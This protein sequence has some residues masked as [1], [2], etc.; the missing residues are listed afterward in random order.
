MF[1][2]RPMASA[3][4][5]YTVETASVADEN[6]VESPRMQLQEFFGSFNTEDTFCL[7][8]SKSD[9]ELRR[10]QFVGSLATLGFPGDPHKLFSA[11]DGDSDGVISAQD[12]TDY[13]GRNVEPKSQEYSIDCTPP[14]E[15]PPTSDA[16]RVSFNLLKLSL[17]RVQ[18][19]R[20]D[21]QATMLQLKDEVKNIV[22]EELAEAFL[23]FRSESSYAVSK[24]PGLGSI[25]EDGSASTA[26]S[27]PTLLLLEERVA[28]VRD[29]M[30]DFVNLA[31]SQAEEVRLV[32]ERV[33]GYQ[34]RMADT[35]NAQKDEVSKLTN[36]LDTHVASFEKMSKSVHDN[37]KRIQLLFESN[38]MFTWRLDNLRGLATER[39]QQAEPDGSEIFQQAEMAVNECGLP[40]HSPPGATSYLPELPNWPEDSQ[41]D[42]LAYPT[43]KASPPN[44]LRSSCST[45]FYPYRD[46]AVAP[47][48][49]TRAS[50]VPQ[51]QWTPASDCIV[52]C[53]PSQVNA[54]RSLSVEAPPKVVTS[55]TSTP[56]ISTHTSA[57]IPGALSA[58]YPP[59]RLS[60]PRSTEI[61]PGNISPHPVHR[62][63]S[64]PQHQGSVAVN[65]PF[66]SRASTPHLAQ[67]LQTPEMP[68]RNLSPRSSVQ[69]FI[70]APP[71]TESVVATQPSTAALN[72]N[73]AL[74]HT[75]RAST[76]TLNGTA[77]A[78]EE[79]P[80]TQ[81]R[82]ISQYNESCAT[83][84]SVSLV[85][86]AKYTESSATTSSAS[87]V[88][89]AKYTESSGSLV[90]PAK[91]SSVSLHLRSNALSPRR[92][93]QQSARGNP[94]Q[95]ASFAESFSLTRT[96]APPS[97]PCAPNA[98]TKRIPPS[99]LGSQER[100]LQLLKSPQVTTRSLI[101]R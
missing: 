18:S 26:P 29:L 44:V 25:S 39:T 15:P 35:L 88:V 97:Y 42:N 14:K 33:A 59:Q 56:L 6:I 16:C 21:Q 70:S 92:Q 60:G 96:T 41:R 30:Q 13:F 64:V 45:P 4:D 10:E 3:T 75:T 84:S 47:P 99:G 40:A 74:R 55:R 58:R 31:A 82:V 43:A 2:L 68:P 50:S 9:R 71:Y 11:I 101:G 17:R 65:Q 77:S 78:P 34:D 89:P 32:K 48:S 91:A 94:L 95:H 61:P 85:V 87:L 86:P 62:T 49:P 72:F 36:I 80:P 93:D 1:P 54:P 28:H 51:H 20:E 27:G 46:L 53:A 8:D 57:E 7:L 38:K 100:P 90:V 69:R 76:A 24:A 81:T 37:E 83:E 67:R 73:L 66:T 5:E 98:W 79:S 63:I 23:K 22:A 52:V 19:E 12:F